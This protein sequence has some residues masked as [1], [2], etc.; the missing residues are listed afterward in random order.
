LKII[1]LIVVVQVLMTYF[2]GAIFR[3]YGL[4]VQEWAFVLVLAISIIPV[5]LIRKVIWNA[6]HKND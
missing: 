4:N 2:G 5:D 6:T 3:C 1:A